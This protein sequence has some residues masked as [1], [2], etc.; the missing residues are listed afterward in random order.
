MACNTMYAYIWHN[1]KLVNVFVRRLYR[2]QKTMFEKIK[3]P[4]EIGDI[5]TLDGLG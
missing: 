5:I 2:K 3:Q 4:L 1:N